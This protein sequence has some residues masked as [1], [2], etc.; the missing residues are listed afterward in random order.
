MVLERGHLLGPLYC[1]A[2]PSVPP[3]LISENPYTPLEVLRT[4]LLLS[5]CV[6]KGKTR[7]YRTFL[8]A[9]MNTPEQRQCLR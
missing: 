6:N 9:F 1:V 4:P 5:T 8:R 3:K 2:A 7:G